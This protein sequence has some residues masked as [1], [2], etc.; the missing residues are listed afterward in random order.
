MLCLNILCFSSYFEYSLDYMVDLGSF[1]ELNS[2]VITK[3]ASGHGLCEHIF[4]LRWMP[5]IL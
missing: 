5:G 4:I 2:T 1:Y 3:L